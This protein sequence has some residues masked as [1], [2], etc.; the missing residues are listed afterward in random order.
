ME[1]L[2]MR[3][4]TISKAFLI[5]FDDDDV[6]DAIQKLADYEDAEEQGLLLRLPCKA[7]DKI[8]CI[9]EKCDFPGDCYTTR[10]CRGCEYRLLFIEEVEFC[11]SMLCQDGALRHPYYTSRE[12]AEA[13]LA[14]KGGVE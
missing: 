5:D 8:Y 7:G 4:S 3:N 1:R 14:E 12:E 6:K 10:K 13:A 2:T 9:Y 11:I